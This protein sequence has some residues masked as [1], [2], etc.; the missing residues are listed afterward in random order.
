MNRIDPDFNPVLYPDLFSPRPYAFPAHCVPDHLI[1]A[2]EKQSEI[3]AFFVSPVPHVLLSSSRDKNLV[4]R[5]IE[6]YFL[7]H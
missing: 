3:S 5:Q 1:P 6:K 7:N 4:K 2:P